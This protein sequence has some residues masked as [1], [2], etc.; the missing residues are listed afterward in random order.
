MERQQLLEA[1]FTK[2]IEWKASLLLLRELVMAHPF[3]ETVKWRFPV[4]TIDGKNVVGLGAFKSYV[5]IW[6]FQGGLLKDKQ[7]K[8][9]NTQEGKTQ[10]MRQWRFHS[11]EEIEQN[12]EL[13]TDYLKEALANQKA[14]KEI[15][16]AKAG[17]KP[18]V[19]PEEL[20]RVLATNNK[21]KDSFDSL[22]LTKKREFA[23]YIELAKRAETKQKRLDKIL[24]MIAEGIGLND[25][26]K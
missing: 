18:L 6:F 16:P 3:E 22:S 24:P 1:Y 4:Y 8:L 2:H 9:V 13:I 25:K 12:A 5:G 10:A 20:Q 23:E 15:K 11:L 21:L 26:Y 14:G 19:I 17:K 7:Q